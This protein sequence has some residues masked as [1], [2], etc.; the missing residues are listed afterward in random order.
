MQA[1]SS[2]SEGA[3]ASSRLALPVAATGV[4]FGDIGTSP[5]YALRACF[6]DVAGVTAD[7]LSVLGIL[8]LIFWS[9]LLVISVK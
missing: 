2:M 4:V 1:S 3:G 5:L 8:S 6:S 9:L 7:A